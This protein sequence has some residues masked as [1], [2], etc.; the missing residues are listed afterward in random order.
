LG[1][2]TRRKLRGPSNC[3]RSEEFKWNFNCEG[4]VRAGA[5]DCWIAD[6]PRRRVDLRYCHQV[7]VPACACALYQYHILSPLPLDSKA[8]IPESDTQ[9]QKYQL[10]FP[11]L[12][13]ITT[14]VFRISA[15]SSLLNSLYC[16][17]Y[18]LP[19]RPGKLKLLDQTYLT[20]YR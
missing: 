2:A 12:R 15:R 1:R 16:D 13:R 18:T 10:L 11:T 3:P 14:S 9:F 4:G 6:L 19:L 20:K 5:V 17:R 7:C 8:S